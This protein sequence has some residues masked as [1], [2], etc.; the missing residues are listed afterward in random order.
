MICTGWLFV[1]IL[2]TLLALIP[3]TAADIA[4][5]GYAFTFCQF[6]C[7]T[8]YGRVRTNGV[9]FSTSKHLRFIYNAFRSNPSVELF[10]IQRVKQRKKND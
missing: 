2:E 10:S 6:L 9:Y 4:V 3:A 7:F 5:D 1:I 8:V